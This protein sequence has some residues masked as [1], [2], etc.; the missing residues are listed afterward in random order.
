VANLFT[1]IATTA[2]R[3]FGPQPVQAI[4]TLPVARKPQ[5][6]AITSATSGRLA[7]PPPPSQDGVPP[8]PPETAL[9]RSYMRVLRSLD[10]DGRNPL[11]R[12]LA[13]RLRRAERK[14]T[15][16]QLSR[17]AK[18]KDELHQ[19]LRALELLES[20]SDEI[21]RDELAAAEQGRELDELKPLRAI[22]ARSP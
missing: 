17:L 10:L 14:P 6:A 1:R 9:L 22:A 19:A 4:N 2:R 5:P 7:L 13:N 15:A 21:D 12:H 18:V 16:E 3:L 20:A 8:P 11:A